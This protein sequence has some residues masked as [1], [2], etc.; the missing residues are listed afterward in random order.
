[1]NIDSGNRYG[2]LREIGSG[3]MATVSLAEDRVL[4]RKVALKILH[5][6]LLGHDHALRRFKTEALAIASFSHENIIRI[7]DFGTQADKPFLAMEFIDGPNLETLLAQGP[8]YRLPNLVALSVLRQVLRGLAAA[9]EIGIYHRDIKPVNILLDKKGQVHIADFGIAFLAQDTGN[10]RTGVWL[11]TPSYSAPEQIEGLPATDKADV[12]AAGILFYRCLTGKLPFQAGTTQALLYSIL[13]A[14]PPKL[15]QSAPRILPALQELMDLMLLRDPAS[16]P[17]AHACLDWLDSHF[18]PP[19]IQPDAGRIAQYLARP[20][21]YAEAEEREIAAYFLAKARAC[22]GGGTSRQAVAWLS[23]AEMFG[24]FPEIASAPAG[25][26]RVAIVPAAFPALD[27]YPQRGNAQG[28]QAAQADRAETGRARRRSL[29]RR[30][31]G[32]IV[33]IAL[34]AVGVGSTAAVLMVQGAG[35]EAEPISRP[36]PEAAPAA[37]NPAPSVSPAAVANASPAA[38]PSIADPPAMPV[39]H[40][41]PIAGRVPENAAGLRPFRPPR[42][43]GTAQ[44]RNAIDTAPYGYLDVMTRPPFAKVFIDD[45]EMGETPLEKPLRLAPG[46]HQLVLRREG[47]LPVETTV[48]VV[49][50]ATGTQA[51]ALLKEG[52]GNP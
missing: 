24:G 37:L 36:A 26:P 15:F 49:A 4:R 8:D 46:N 23:A 7:F 50:N 35:L 13:Q 20:T 51:Y 34:A 48:H 3:A 19:G 22:P 43:K 2:I 16:R 9:H 38:A 21:E 52:A 29:I 39:P 40:A 5:P 41:A 45:R 12:F 11:G 44:L 32:L 33:S 47:C 42:P 18:P 17:S 30:K 14:N 1:M 10:T 25:A 27:A 28:P 31:T 6:H